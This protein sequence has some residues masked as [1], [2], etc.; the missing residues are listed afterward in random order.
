MAPAA[1]Y[2]QALLSNISFNLI[3]NGLN[4]FSV[5]KAPKISNLIKNIT[6]VSTIRE[7]KSIILSVMTVPNNFPTGILSVLYKDPHLATSP[8]RG[9]PRFTR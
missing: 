4:A 5:R 6:T 9:K 8:S 3:N 7:K 1:R 2:I